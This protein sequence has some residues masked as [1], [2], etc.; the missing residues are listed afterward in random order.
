MERTN[1]FSKPQ[2]ENTSSLLCSYF[3]LPLIPQEKTPLFSQALNVCAL[4]HALVWA[5]TA[6]CYI[7]NSSAEHFTAGILSSG[8]AQQSDTPWQ[9]ATYTAIHTPYSVSVLLTSWGSKHS[10]AAFAFSASCGQQTC[11]RQ[12]RNDAQLCHFTCYSSFI[13]LCSVI[14]KK[15][16]SPL[17]FQLGFQVPLCTVPWLNRNRKCPLFYAGLQ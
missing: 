10:F 4:H 13:N 16:F 9:C 12:Q 2:A 8:L 3:F 5:F 14:V 15:H 17:T 11:L 1:Y 6:D 7:S